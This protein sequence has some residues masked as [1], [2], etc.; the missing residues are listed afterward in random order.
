MGHRYS[1][2]GG[3]RSVANAGAPNTA[4][5]DVYVLVIVHMTCETQM[6]DSFA[7]VGLVE[8]EKNEVHG[9]FGR[10]QQCREQW[11]REF[12]TVRLSCVLG[13]V[14][15]HALLVILG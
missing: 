14:V 4:W 2:C 1:V 11:L 6:S 7:S 12:V 10:V 8:K 13:D 5:L 3:H 15:A 9:M